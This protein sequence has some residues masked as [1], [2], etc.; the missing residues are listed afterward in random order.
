MATSKGQII[1]DYAISKIGCAYIYGGYGEKLCSPSFRKERAKA[2]PEQKN[3]IYKY[4]QVLG[5][6]KSNCNGCKWNGKQA[7]DCAQLTRYSCKAAGQELVSGANSQ[8]KKTPWDQKGTIGSLPD[9]PGILL[10][11]ANTKGVMTHTGVY[12]GGGYVSEARGAKAGVIKSVL[13]DYAWTHWAALPGVL[14]GE[15]VQTPTQQE[16]TKQ[17]PSKTVSSASS[18]EVITMRT[19]RNNSKGTQVKVLQWLLNTNGYDVGEVDGIFGKKTIAA[20]KAFQTAKGL[21]VDGI[22]GKDTW[23]AILA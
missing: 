3:N 21:D 13:S 1:A 18:S 9:V 23:S 20:V 7:Y 2:Y 19:L 12:L 16:Q 22:V 8:W 14:T 6:G 11:H 17:E 5:S 4:C 10:Y 15:V